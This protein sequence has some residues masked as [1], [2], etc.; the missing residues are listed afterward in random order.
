MFVEGALDFSDEDVDWLAD[1]ALTKKLHDAQ[2]ALAQLLAQAAQG[3]R[4]REGYTVALTGRPNV[5]KSTLP[6]YLAGAAVALAPDIAGHTRHVLRHHLNTRG[7]PRPAAPPARQ[8][9]G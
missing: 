3:R 6:N 1:S 2:H 4:L 9:V 7:P 5:G 8:R